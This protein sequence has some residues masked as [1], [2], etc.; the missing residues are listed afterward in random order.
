RHQLIINKLN[1]SMTK[2][3]DMLDVED[4]MDTLSIKLLGVVPDD[5]NITISTNKGEPVVLSNK[6]KAGNAYINIA[7]RLMGEE[8]PFM[9]LV[10]GNNIL[11]SLVNIFKK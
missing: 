4:I 7:R 10:E 3:G 11:R 9:N 5:K 2:K 1:Y 8:I 6:S